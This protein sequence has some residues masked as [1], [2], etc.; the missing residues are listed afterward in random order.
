[1]AWLP[2]TKFSGRIHKWIQVRGLLFGVNPA[3]FLPHVATILR[4]GTRL[5]L[6]PQGRSFQGTSVY[7]EHVGPIPHQS[8]WQ[9]GPQSRLRHE[10]TV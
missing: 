5:Q 4:S 2:S 3:R 9:E 7:I 8:A 10:V 1:M 6:I